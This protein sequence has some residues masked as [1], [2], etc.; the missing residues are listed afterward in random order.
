MSFICKFC[1]LYPCSLSESDTCRGSLYAG[2]FKP[3]LKCP[4]DIRKRWTDWYKSCAR[5]GEGLVRNQDPL[6]K[7]HLCASCLEIILREEY[8]QGLKSES[9]DE[10]RKRIVDHLQKTFIDLIATAA[11]FAAQGKIQFEDLIDLYPL[12]K[13]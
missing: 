7:D 13:N 1:V 8:F 12:F 9:Y 4:S 10:L 2:L 5:C 11:F 6:S 3:A